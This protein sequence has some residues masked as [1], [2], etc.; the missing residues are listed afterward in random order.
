MVA[1]MA[2]TVPMRGKKAM[3]KGRKNRTNESAEGRHVT[4]AITL[5][6]DVERRVAERAV[7]EERSFSQ[8]VARLLRTALDGL[9]AAAKAAS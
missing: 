5:P 2:P 1:R 3:A 9:E 4:K 8:T 6:P 7:A